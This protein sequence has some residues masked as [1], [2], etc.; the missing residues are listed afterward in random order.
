MCRHILALLSIALLIQPLRA[1]VALQQ[2]HNPDFNNSGV[3]DFPDF[4]LFVAGFGSR[5]GDEKYDDRFDLDG[6]GEIG[7]GDF[8]RFAEN[9]GKTVTLNGGANPT[10]GD[11]KI[12]GSLFISK[13]W[14]GHPVGFDLLTYGDV[15][16]VAFY[17]ADRK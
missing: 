12:L 6:D 15:Q 2:D 7:F 1:D 10:A 17:D 3:V 9:F 14:A 11:I 5:Q 4:L 16:F 8:V 13:V